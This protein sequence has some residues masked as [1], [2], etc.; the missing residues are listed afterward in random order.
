MY[1]ALGLISSNTK[2]KI[3]KVEVISHV[4]SYCSSKE[5]EINSR[6]KTGKLINIRKLNNTY[7]NTTIQVRNLKGNQ[8]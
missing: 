7:L 3:R 6:N 2:K 8:K 4:Y 1:K 5:V